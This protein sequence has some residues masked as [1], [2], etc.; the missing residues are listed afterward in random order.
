M[1]LSI[2]ISIS[3]LRVSNADD[4]ASSISCSLSSELYESSNRDI[5]VVSVL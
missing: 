2:S 1:F 4:K 3:C 5:T